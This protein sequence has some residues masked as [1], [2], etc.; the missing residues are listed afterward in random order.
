MSRAGAVY[1]AATCPMRFGRN[2]TVTLPSATT[3]AFPVGDKKAGRGRRGSM[4]KQVGKGV[5]AG[6][7]IQCWIVIK[8][9]ENAIEMSHFLFDC[10]LLC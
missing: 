9:K 7:L 10:I 5:C 8:E 4:K 2:S 1:Y 3:M 6:F